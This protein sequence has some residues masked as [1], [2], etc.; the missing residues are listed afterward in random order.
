VKQEAAANTKQD[1]K[2]GAVGGG[3]GAVVGG[4]AGGGKGAAIGAVAGSAGTVLATKGNEVE[5]E[6]GTVVST[7][8]QEPLKVLVPVD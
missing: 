6:A 1:A 4:I 3:L 8:L 2:K 5:L 7:T